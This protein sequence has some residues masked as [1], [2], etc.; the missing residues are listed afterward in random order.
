[1]DKI[2]IKWINCKNNRYSYYRPF[3]CVVIIYHHPNTNNYYI[4]H[5][6]H[7]KNGTLNM[8]YSDI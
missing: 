2:D 4:E 6:G 8:I 7:Y 5:I 1:M 3:L